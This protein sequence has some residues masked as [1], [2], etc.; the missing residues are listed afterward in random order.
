MNKNVLLALVA[1]VALGAVGYFA[2]SGNMA[3]TEVNNPPQGTPAV[4]PPA[5]GVGTT[6]TTT[7]TTQTT[8]TVPAGIVKVT[9]QNNAFTPRNIEIKAGESIEFVNNSSSSIFIASD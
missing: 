5:G 9:Y 6:S 7:T 3:P 8:V 1:V 4:N 2:F